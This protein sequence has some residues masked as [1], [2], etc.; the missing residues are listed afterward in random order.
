[1]PSNIHLTTF[2]CSVLAGLAPFYPNG[3]SENKNVTEIHG[4]PSESSLL[5]HTE[6]ILKQFT[7]K[8]GSTGK[9]VQV[10]FFMP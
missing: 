4:V 6:S 9:Y 10:I 5:K 3:L 1:M 7:V 8:V 2:M